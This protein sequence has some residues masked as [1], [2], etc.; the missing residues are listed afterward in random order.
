MI[1]NTVKNSINLVDKSRNSN[2]FEDC[3]GPTKKKKRRIQWFDEVAKNSIT[4]GQRLFANSKINSSFKK[5][6]NLKVNQPKTSIKLGNNEQIIS[7]IAG[8]NRQEGKSIKKLGISMKQNEFEDFEYLSLK[9]MSRTNFNDIKFK[10]S[11]GLHK[12]KSLKVFTKKDN[13]SIQ[14]LNKKQRQNL[15]LVKSAQKFYE[16]NST[17][18]LNFIK[19]VKA[20]DLQHHP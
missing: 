4:A 5:N 20:L 2:L 9:E 1:I 17:S 7:L 16:N 8:M 12:R 18:P 13:R 14:K 15:S 3:V 11:M 6:S 10:N 19:G